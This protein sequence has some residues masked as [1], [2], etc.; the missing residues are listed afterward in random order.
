MGAGKAV[1]A[2]SQPLTPHLTSPL[3]GGRD[4]FGRGEVGGGSYLRRNDGE[5]AREQRRGAGLA[6]M[7]E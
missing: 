2:G 7:V 6:L 3:K 5:G 4:E 1:V